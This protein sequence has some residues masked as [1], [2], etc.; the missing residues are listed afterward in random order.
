VVILSADLGLRLK[1]HQHQIKAISPPE[2]E[3][4]VEPPDEAERELEQTRRE[5]AKYQNRRPK[6]SLTF[7]DGNE[8][9]QLSMLNPQSKPNLPGLLPQYMAALNNENDYKNYLNRHEQWTAQV[10]LFCPCK[11]R[12][13][14]DGSAEATNVEA[15]LLLPEFLTAIDSDDFS[16]EPEAPRSIFDPM[17]SLG[18]IRT[19]ADTLKPRPETRVRIQNYRLSFQLPTVVHN[20]AENWRSFASNSW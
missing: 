5:L 1:L 6:L 4:L 16:S 15:E 10:R 12:I 20:R 18:N 2:T 11:L 7:L 8:H 19:L 13:E 9:A 14:N 3:R 17:H